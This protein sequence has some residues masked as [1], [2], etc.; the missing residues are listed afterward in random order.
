MLL[1]H[2]LKNA[3]KDSE[4]ELRNHI[5]D[6][7]NEVQDLISFISDLLAKSENPDQSQIEFNLEDEIK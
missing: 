6:N 7:L 1:S 3:L 2:Y 5:Q 4:I